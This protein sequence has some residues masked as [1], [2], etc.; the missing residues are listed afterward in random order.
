[1]SNANMPSYSKEFLV[2]FNNVGQRLWATYY[3]PASTTV[4]GYYI[5][6]SIVDKQNNVYILSLAEN[7]NTIATLDTHKDSIKG[8][9]DLCLLKLNSQGQRLWNSYFGGEV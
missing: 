8:F 7:S 1:M 6:S 2:K 3:G 4:G 5:T 9:S